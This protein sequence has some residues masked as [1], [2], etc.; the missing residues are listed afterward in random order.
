MQLNE[1]N[2]DG[3]LNNEYQSKEIYKDIFSETS[4]IMK[5]RARRLSR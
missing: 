5:N 1:L 3:Y 4:P 2:E